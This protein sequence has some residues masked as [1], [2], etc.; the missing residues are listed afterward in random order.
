MGPVN[1]PFCNYG[2]CRET[3]N[4]STKKISMARISSNCTTMDYKLSLIP[5]CSDKV[6]QTS[7]D[8]LNIPKTVKGYSI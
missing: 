2:V 7:Y 1:R 5:R 3:E 8:S 4:K 6:I